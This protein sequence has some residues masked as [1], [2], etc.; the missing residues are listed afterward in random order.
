MR[1]VEEVEKVVAKLS[2]QE[3]AEFRAWFAEYDAELWDRQ[4]E[5][6]ASEG[7][8]DRFAAEALEE[9]RRGETRDL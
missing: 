3:L 5:K 1:S 8:L 6:D 4:F 7:K 9:D 2:P